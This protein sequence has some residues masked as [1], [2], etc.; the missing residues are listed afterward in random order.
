MRRQAVI[1]GREKK[2][3]TQ[4]QIA[5]KIGI[6]VVSYNKFENGKVG[7]KEVNLKKLAGILGIYDIRKF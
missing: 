5:N 1:D 6:S 2:G 4:A 7:L 3:L